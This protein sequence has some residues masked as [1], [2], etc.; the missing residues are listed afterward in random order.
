MRIINQVPFFFTIILVASSLT[1]CGS[2][3][4]LYHAPEPNAEQESKTANKTVATENI[5]KKQP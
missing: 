4:A 5:D 3:G 2:K 1:A